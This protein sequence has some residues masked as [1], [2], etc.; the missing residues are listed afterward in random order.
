LPKSVIQQIRPSAARAPATKSPTR[1]IGKIEIRQFGEYPQTIAPDNIGREL[2]GALKAK[3]LRATGDKYTFDGEAY[4]AFDKPFKPVDYPEYE[5]HGERYIRVLADPR[6]SDSILSN[7]KVPKKGEPCWVQVQPI[8]WMVD[9]GGWWV[10]Y[11]ALF[12][13]VQFDNASSYDGDFSKTNMK[14]YLDKYFAPQMQ[15]GRVPRQS[16]QEFGEAT[17]KISHGVTIIDEPMS[18]GE[19]IGVYIKNGKSFM[20][21]GPSGVG[22]TARVEAV[23]PNLTAVPLWNGVLPEDIVGKVRYPSGQVAPL[24]APDESGEAALEKLANGGVWVPPDWY[25]ELVKKCDAEPNKQHV[26]F[27]DEVTN[28]KP[29]TQS[30]IF[31]VVLKKSISPSKGKLPANAVIVL[32]GNDKTES[33]AAYNMPA[34]LFRRMSGHIYLQ[35]NLPEWLEW[36]SEKSRKYPDDPNRLNAHPLVA[37]F[38]STYPDAFYS[39]YDEDNPGQWAIDPRGWEQISDIIYDN[40]NTIRRELIENKIGVENAATLLAFARE[41]FLTAENVLDGNYNKNDVP[42]D[43]TRRLATALGMRHVSPRQVEKVREFIGKHLGAEN[44]AIFD[45]KWVGD[46]DERAI[47]ISQMKE[48]DR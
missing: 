42:E 36:A 1:K 17:R 2:E 8:E 12:A 9:P 27:I 45:S 10:A 32:A 43:Q 46:N 47:Q 38:L 15:H 19:Q 35:L 5:Y 23:D 11:K 28:A 22:K 33:G 40:G 4:D 30:L 14:K 39:D 25:V 7:G 37:A 6:D 21:H 3:I 24:M 29:T 16:A 26:L 44:L 34:P 20:L 48:K 18:V 41:P 13:G 31:H